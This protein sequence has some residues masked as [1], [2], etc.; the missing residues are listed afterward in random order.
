MSKI[1]LD[2]DT[3]DI[4]I[5]SK[6][7]GELHYTDLENMKWMDVILNILKNKAGS[8]QMDDHFYETLI[9][10][11]ISQIATNMRVCFE[12]YDGGIIPA[13]IYSFLLATSGSSKG[14]TNSTLKNLFFKDFEDSFMTMHQI[15]AKLNLEHMAE[16]KSRLE[17]MSEE[18]ALDYLTKRFNC[19]PNFIF[20]YNDSTEPGFKALR[21][22]LTLSGSG[23]TN[24]ELDEIG[25][26]M[27]KIKEFLSAVLECY[28]VGV[29]N[30]KLTKTESSKDTAKIPATFLAFGTGSTLLDGGEMEKDFMSILRQG[31][32]RR[33]TFSYTENIK[34]T[35]DDEEFD[36]MKILL[37]AKSSEDSKDSLR[38]MNKFKL[39]SEPKLFD[40]VILVP[41]AIWA[42]V[43]EYQRD[44]NKEVS[45]LSEFEDLV[46]LNIK[47]SYWTLSKIM[48]VYA[49]MDGKDYVEQIHFD[50]ALKYV[51][52][53]I[54]DFK[55]MVRRKSNF[56]RVALFI[57]TAKRELTLFDF[58][59]SMPFY[60]NA[61]KQ[62]KMEMLELAQAYAA[63]HN[64]LIQ[65]KIKE[66]IIYYTGS[67]L[68][69]VDLNQIKLS[70]SSHITE[71]FVPL[72]GK[73][74]D[75]YNIPC[76]NT[77]YSIHHFI[78]NYR[79]GSN[80]IAGFNIVVLDIDDGT[81]LDTAKAILKESKY[82]ITTTRN[83]NKEKNGK[84][85]DRFRIFLPMTV[86]LK[87]NELDFKAFMTN[88][89]EDF[90]IE[91]DEACKDIARFYFGHAGA[92]YAYND[93]SL[94]DPADYIPNTEPN[95]KRIKFNSELGDI[96]SLEK[97]FLKRMASGNRND[98]LIKFALALVDADKE[99]EEIESRCMTLNSRLEDPISQK[100]I[101]STILST[102]RKK[103]YG[104][105]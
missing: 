49:F 4:P 50:R 42:K 15:R 101:S 7:S 91:V 10:N 94:F 93:G 32:A 100:E 47:H 48:S 11:K 99:Y 18:Q 53:S 40:K 65:H 45:K 96:G 24:I 82:L 21:E 51:K 35:E 37:R 1:K 38:I 105:K 8:E 83:H 6:V 78:D 22:K 89:M 104:G 5:E 27:H 95:K 85:R 17:G 68:E 71:N 9:N 28:D 76:S 102:V 46:M 103:L 31:L 74:D 72:S 84:I 60:K 97:W 29:L 43:L 16:D 88:V 39:L 56:E 92:D 80:A 55:K 14:K 61:T 25:I 66:G 86:E 58:T 98:M 36:P 79:K 12:F 67:M 52:H 30:Q 59:E 90:P 87:L 41:D 75:L 54:I 44:C 64:M 3:E 81:D 33:C 57:C 63:T 77:N 34:D 2:D 23:A 19:L 13:N 70:M 62:S 26:N 20:T 73:W 69:E